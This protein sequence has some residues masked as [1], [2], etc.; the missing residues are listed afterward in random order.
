MS[1]YN[2]FEVFTRHFG[3]RIEDTPALLSTNDPS[4]AF[5]VCRSAMNREE[6]SL[7]STSIRDVVTGREYGGIEVFQFANEFAVRNVD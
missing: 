2:R 3:V 4:E 6:G 7:A 5:R 1:L